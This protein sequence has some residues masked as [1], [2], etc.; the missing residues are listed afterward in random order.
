VSSQ[1]APTPEEIALAYAA[2][3]PVAVPNQSVRAKILGAILVAGIGV[4]ASVMSCVGQSFS[5]RQARAQEGIAQ[6]LQLLRLQI[7][8][9]CSGERGA[10]R[11]P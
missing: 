1:D 9:G 3:V 7:Q 8:Q 10:A 2:S 5:L 4:G 11:I 6:E